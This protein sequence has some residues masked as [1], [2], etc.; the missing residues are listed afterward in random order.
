MSTS[1]HDANNIKDNLIRQGVP[2]DEIQKVYRTLKGRGYGEEEARARSREA[3]QRLKQVKDLEERRRNAQAARSRARSESPAASAKARRAMDRLPVVPP[4]LR[5][6]INR[7]AYSNGFLISRFPQLVDDFLTYFDSTRP[8]FVSRP[9]L[10]L[11]ADEQGFRGRN[12]HH[13]S[14]IDSLDA[15][16]ESASRLLGQRGAGSAIHKEE[17]V[18]DDLRSREP[19][20]VEF[21]SVF[22]QPHEALRTS[23]EYLGSAFRMRQRVPVSGLARVVKDGLRLI[24]ITDALER[25]RLALLLDVARD[26]NLEK[27]PGAR[28][29]G[30]MAEAETLFRAAFEG[31][32]RFTH[33]LYPALLKMI[34]AFYAEE[35][36]SPEKVA[37]IRRFLEV[38]DA[39]LLTW[40]GWQRRVQELREKE[41]RERQARELARLEQEKTEAFSIRF[42]GTLA[43]LASLFPESGIDRIE[44]GVFLLPYFT[45]RIFPNSPMFQARAVDLES[46][47]SQDMMGTVLIL[48]SLVDDML[49]SLDAA[50]LEKLVG[51]EGFAEELFA[52]RDKWREA[53][54]RVF[55]PYLDSVREFARESGVDPRYT[56]M[57]RESALAR[58]V[59]ERIEQ[60]R[61]AAVRGFGRLA[62]DRDRFE[63]PRVY[64]L[65]SQLSEI[66]TEAGSVLNQSTLT[67]PDPMSRRLM[68]EVSRGGYVDYVAASK[69]ATVNYHPVTRQVKR[70]VEARYRQGI[71]DIP[72][73]AQVAF[74]D[75]LRGVAYLYDSYV[76]EAKSPATMGPH[77]VAVST[78]AE[79]ALWNKERAVGSRAAQ[80]SLQATLGEQFPGRYRD[81]LT[82]LKNKDF[83]LTELPR[84]MQEMR[85]RGLALS[86]LMV[87]VDHFKWVNDTL[88][89]PRGDEVLTATAS[90]LLDNIREGDVAI[91]YGGEEI[92][93][94]APSDLHTA[95]ILAER[96]RFAQESRVLSREA[97]QDVQRIG[98]DRH[99][100]CG[101][102]SIGVAALGAIS[103]PAKAVDRVDRALYAAKE[104]RNVVVAL[105]SD[106]AGSETLTTYAEYRVRTAPAG[107]PGLGA[108]GPSA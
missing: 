91:R 63:G 2:A 79:H 46:M 31:L 82:G 17:E 14:L 71:L 8:D 70:W 83:F 33:E 18:R 86:V 98:F 62:A 72:A 36:T 55:E 90:M 32:A 52:I 49:S 20:A 95:I 80:K 94:V 59:V 74:L 37:A 24:A 92:L 1:D 96:L 75:V 93:I 67:A 103:E 30:E 38:T 66:L 45:N 7:Y 12:P 81:A 11:L 41:L 28:M 99:E 43:M 39:D 84:A 21:L 3:L 76:N 51:R 48:H 54:P 64:E 23:L 85:S 89:H 25:D 35:D 105:E 108:R 47:S 56:E 16:R 6:R 26:V 40:A 13:L 87:D 19:F 15:L 53:Y 42:Q 106:A 60:L 58:S 29:A 101:T 107:S 57:L 5:R 22:T 50:R 100:P 78:S 44:Q 65:A 88:G 27:T 61:N 69:P 10:A 77:G 68:E 102:L 9:L 97:M 104:R 73:Q 34:A 4:W